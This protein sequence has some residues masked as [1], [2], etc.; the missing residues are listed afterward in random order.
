MSMARAPLE[1]WRL[2]R[3]DETWA[4]RVRGPGGEGGQRLVRASPAVDQRL[5]CLGDKLLDLRLAGLGDKGTTTG[6]RMLGGDQK[7]QLAVLG[8]GAGHVG[9]R[10]DV[11]DGNQVIGQR[12]SAGHELDEFPGRR[13]V[14]PPVG[15]GPGPANAGSREGLT[16]ERGEAPRPY[17][18]KDVRDGR[19][20][21]RTPIK[22]P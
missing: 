5:R 17:L 12:T 4:K 15:D 1:A 14:G 8:L 2:H 21:V 3:F 13:R 11:A 10:G 22:R 6:E 18:G 9:A 16:V 19:S 20:A 7:G